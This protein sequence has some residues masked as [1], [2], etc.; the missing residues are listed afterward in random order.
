M[1]DFRKTLV[2]GEFEFALNG[3][4]Q[5][6]HCFYSDVID[7]G[8]GPGPFQVRATLV[9][10]A[11]YDDGLLSGERVLFGDPS[12]FCQSS[13]VPGIPKLSV[14]AYADV[15]TGCLRI[16]AMLRQ[17][18]ARGKVKI[19]WWAEKAPAATVPAAPELPKKEAEPVRFFIH[20]APRTMHPGQQ[21]RFS[22]GGAP[23]GAVI[24]WEAASENGGSFGENGLYTAPEEQGIYQIKAIWEETG[25][26]ASLYLMVR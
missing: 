13:Y 26:E 23:E 19:I 5:K 18:P 11:G 6:G 25:R 21:F 2:Q 7:T 16:G 9:D 10:V 17:G 8:F 3:T 12:V 22:C 4:E 14:G 1:D 24:R 20:F 15:E